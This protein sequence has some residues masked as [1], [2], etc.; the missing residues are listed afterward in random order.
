VL[1]LFEAEGH[2][3]QHPQ[4]RVGALDQRVRQVVQ[5]GCLDAQDVP[6]DLPPEFDE[7]GD[8]ASLGPGQPLVEHGESEDPLRADGN[9]QLLL[10]QVRPVKGRVDRGD[11]GQ[12]ALLPWGE[13]LRVA[14]QGVAAPLQ[15]R[16][17]L[18]A[19]A[20]DSGVVPDYRSGFVICRDTQGPLI[21]G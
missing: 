19:A 14:P 11:P 21:G 9:A 4:L 7:G 16:Y 20:N 12:F 10:H 15:P 3:V 2:P 5:H 13:V 6:L 8:A 1:G 18:V 17:P